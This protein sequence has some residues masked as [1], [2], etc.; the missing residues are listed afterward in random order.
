MNPTIDSL[1]TELCYHVEVD[2]SNGVEFGDDKIS[3]L[4]WILKEPQQVNVL[5]RTSVWSSAVANDKEFIIEI[6]P[7]FVLIIKNVHEFADMN[8]D[9]KN[10]T[11][12]HIAQ[13]KSIQLKSNECNYAISLSLI[14]NNFQI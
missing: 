13:D 10:C 4:Q 12:Q 8:L 7:R 5:S 11:N 9:I 3:I 14:H 6:G 2:V 1:K